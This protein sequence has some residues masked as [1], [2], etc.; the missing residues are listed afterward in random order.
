[1]KK[2]AL[3]ALAVLILYAVTTHVPLVFPLNALFIKA[4]E[5]RLDAD[6]LA[7][8]F[9]IY[10]WRSLAATE[11]EAT[12]KGGFGLRAEKA[13]VDYDLFSFF[14]TGRLRLECSLEGV[15]LGKSNSIINSL[16]DML[17]LEPMENVAFD[18][19]S[20]ELYVGVKD[21]ITKNLSLVSDKLKIFGSATTD[22]DDNIT[23]LLQLHINEEI[24]GQMPSVMREGL[25]K[26][27]DGPWS[28][29]HFGI[30]GNYSRPQIKIITER[31]RMNI[32]NV[33]L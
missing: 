17:Q 4:V 32:S 10:L 5:R 33:N 25:L 22:M 8:S 9:K 6:I 24:T 13:R 14:A 12:G 20:A 15:K 31:F 23:C 26:K 21:T 29:M 1:M 7:R 2:T 11:I 18:T 27:E 16:V 19:V 30:I 3:I 28:S